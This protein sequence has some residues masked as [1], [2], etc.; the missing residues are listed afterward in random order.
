MAK[1]AMSLNR[2]LR[3][4]RSPGKPPRGR[5]ALAVIPYLAGML[6]ASGFCSATP[7]TVQVVFNGEAT[8]QNIERTV[9]FGL[10]GGD[11]W[12]GTTTG[13]FAMTRI[14][15]DYPGFPVT[16][17][18]AF[19]IEPRE[20]ISPGQT[21]LFNWD[22]L[23]NGTTNIGGMGVTKAN[24][25]RELFARHYP[26]IGA[27]LDA[28]HA[29]AMQIAIWEIVREDSGTLNVYTGNT[30]FRNPEDQA[31]LD[32]AQIYLSS[33]TGSGPRLPYLHALTFVGV[34]DLLVEETPEPGYS[35][36]VGLLLVGVPLYIR[37]RRS[38]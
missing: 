30:R 16:D 18:Y 26:A 4:I 21:V 23:E 8:A 27:P 20:F 29:S 13:M 11:N 28:E 24:L 19:C 37:R 12:Y 17:F 10:P 7:F 3:V 6:L 9:D 22:A 32:L 38:A 15:G 34:Q 31:A 14:G 2:V 25:L 36:L 33:I 5:R 35:L 1:Y